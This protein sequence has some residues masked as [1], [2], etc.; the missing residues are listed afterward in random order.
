[1]G[2]RSGPIYKTILN[3]LLEAKL[4][5]VVETK[6]DEISFIRTNYPLKKQKTGA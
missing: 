4:D 3:H 2:Y 1:M 5:G 6:A